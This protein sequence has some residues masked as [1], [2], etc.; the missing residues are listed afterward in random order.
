MRRTSVR[1][2]IVRMIGPLPSRL[3]L[4]RFVTVAAVSASAANAQ[5]TLQGSVRDAGSGAPIASAV[6]SL[7]ELDRSTSAAS[8]GRYVLRGVPSGPLHVAVRAIG[9]RP[10]VLHAMVPA[11]GVLEI[12]FTLVR[13]PVRLSPATIRST[14]IPGSSTS[15]GRDSGADREVTVATLGNHPLQ[16]EPDV[17]QALTG[18]H[19]VVQPE[20][21]SGLH[22]RGGAADQTAYLLDGIPVLNPYHA[23]GMFSAFNPDAIARV[24]L[25]SA[26]PF[27]GLPPTLAGAVEA[28]TRAPGT[29]VRTQGG[30]STT[31]ARLTIDGPA[32]GTGGGF[33]VSARTGYPGLL[34]PRR[35]TSYLRGGTSDLLATLQ[36]RLLG[37]EARLLAYVNSNDVNAAAS[38]PGDTA[39]GGA[40]A[41]NRFE[42]GSHSLGST[43]QR[44]RPRSLLRVVG[45]SAM[46]TANAD[47]ASQRGAL[48]LDTKRSDLGLSV[49]IEQRAERSTSAA[50]LRLDRMRTTY[51]VALDSAQTPPTMIGGR[52]TVA[53]AFA[54][55]AWDLRRGVVLTGAMA[56][57]TTGRGMGV[58]PRTQLRWRVHDRF[59]LVGSYARTLQFA[60]SLRNAES[61]VGTVFPSDLYAVANAGGVPVAHST[62]GVAAAA[63]EPAAGVRLDVEA[64]ARSLG[65]LVLV[66]PVDGEPFSTSR[67]G[68][69]SGAARGVSAALT[70]ASA[71]YNVTLS[72]ALQRV[73]LATRD[74]SYVPEHAAT[75]LVEAGVIVFPTNTMTLRIGAVSMLGRRTTTIVN[76]F[77]WE[78][79]NLVDRGCEFGGSPYLGG[80]ALG[81]TPLPAYVRVDL[82][83]RQ[84]LHR[85]IA[86]YDVQL[87]L[88]GTFT[89][90]LGRHNVL[91]Y[92]TAPSTSARA[93]VEFRR[94][95]P[96]VVGIEWRF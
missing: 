22:V 45:W 67:F 7:A 23:A 55:Q 88:F 59:T 89:N 90:L 28:E 69:G 13:A 16:A 92:S 56:L 64:Y 17:L 77:E 34:A 95:S 74:T 62:Q 68:V 75:H 78:A 53:T 65:D 8:D 39:A 94:P 57:S 5:A 9:F 86:G 36:G 71:R 2:Q 37:G 63:W 80:A 10:L 41:R 38:L 52:T 20:A 35:E 29:A 47:W 70:V 1:V 26:S 46:T 40:G 61:V 48:S 11:S 30:A 82:G 83:V 60:Q 96:L 25:S 33:L 50:G 19:V 6:V 18:G 79:C 3:G 58:S 12:S 73:R 44:E 54:Q 76:G 4:R 43:W 42:W 31:Q 85:W 32:G 24:R 27:A 81:G 72:Y 51:A 66:A 87:A 15:D 14:T 21:P 91:T 93:A 49:T 84:H